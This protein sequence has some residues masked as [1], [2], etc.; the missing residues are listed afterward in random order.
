MSVNNNIISYRYSSDFNT[1]YKHYLQCAHETHTESVR[2]GPLKKVKYVSLHKYLQTTHM[3]AE[4]KQIDLWPTSYR[5]CLTVNTHIAVIYYVILF[6]NHARTM[7]RLTSETIK[8]LNGNSLY[9]TSCVYKYEM[10]CY[11]NRLS[12]KMTIKINTTASVAARRRH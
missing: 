7:I 10:D 2:V 1:V 5:Q 12:Y 6:P 11:E 3:D 9:L 4:M 8:I